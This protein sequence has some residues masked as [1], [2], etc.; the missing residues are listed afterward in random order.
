MF[1]IEM[2]DPITIAAQFLFSCWHFLAPSVHQEVELECKLKVESHDVQRQWLQLLH[3]C[4]FFKLTLQCHISQ[5]S[6]NNCTCR[7]TL[8]FYLKTWFPKAFAIMTGY[9]F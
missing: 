9:M 2:V 1:L 3:I 8:L 4:R 6:A 5:L 7:K